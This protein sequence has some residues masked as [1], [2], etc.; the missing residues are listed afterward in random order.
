MH[1]VAII[2]QLLHSPAS[3]AAAASAIFAAIEASDPSLLLTLLSDTV[4]RRWLSELGH[5]DT[6]G[7]KV[8]PIRFAASMH[9]AIE[10]AAGAL[11]PEDP[12]VLWL[13]SLAVIL[14]CPSDLERSAAVPRARLS[15]MA[16]GRTDRFQPLSSAA[17]QAPPARQ[18]A[19]PRYAAISE[20]GHLPAESERPNLVAPHE[21]GRLSSAQGAGARSVPARQSIAGGDATGSEPAPH[22]AAF[23]PDRFRGEATRGAGLYF[24]LNALRHL[25]TAD[26]QFNPPFVGHLFQRVAQYAGIESGDPILLWTHVT[27]DQADPAGIDE[28]LLRLWVLKVRHWCWRSGK[29]TVKEIVQRP[30]LVT[31]TRTDLDVSL[32]LDSVDIRIRRI[33]LDLDPGWLPW[34][35]RV[36]RFHYVAHGE[37][38][39]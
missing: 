6:L 17:R 27:L 36:V 24:L 34:F 19:E 39:A 10:Q 14:A 31:L 26:D 30:G 28:R 37:V 18:A 12:R 11:G 16:I 21:R 5:G 2:E 4:V 7:H 1:F 23:R 15:L 32:A 20:S 25:K 33:G 9:K 38:H 3:W 8:A 29:I 22:N 13:A 35:G